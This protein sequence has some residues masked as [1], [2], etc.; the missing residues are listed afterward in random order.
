MIAYVTK[1]PINVDE[2]IHSFKLVSTVMQPI[3]RPYTRRYPEGIIAVEHIHLHM[4]STPSS[5]LRRMFSIPSCSATDFIENQDAN[6][7]NDKA[8]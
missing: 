3:L 5:E 1:I 7:K 2:K 6:K 4:S 8:N